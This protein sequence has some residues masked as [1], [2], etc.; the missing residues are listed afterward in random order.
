MMFKL[1]LFAQHNWRRLRGF[2]QLG[3]VIEGLPT[4]RQ[5]LMRGCKSAI[6]FQLNT[7]RRVHVLS[8][9]DQKSV[10]L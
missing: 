1:G 9:R 7:M 8:D 4:I 3:K 6:K 5:Q 2:R 10:G